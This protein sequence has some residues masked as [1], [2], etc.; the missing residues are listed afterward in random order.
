METVLPLRQNLLRVKICVYYDTEI[1]L[2]GVGPTEIFILNT[3]FR[4]PKALMSNKE[5]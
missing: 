1:L 3:C 2:T 5:K 4:V